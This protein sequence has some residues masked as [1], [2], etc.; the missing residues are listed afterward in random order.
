MNTIECSETLSSICIF[1]GPACN[2]PERYPFFD[3]VKFSS[4]AR[5]LSTIRFHIYKEE[6]DARSIFYP[7]NSKQFHILLRSLPFV[8]ISG[9]AKRFYSDRKD[10]FISSTL[11][12]N[13]NYLAADN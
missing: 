8:F 3:L 5:K 2:K 12:D 4:T 9:H 11:V 13:H 6:L 10:V 1:I 7:F